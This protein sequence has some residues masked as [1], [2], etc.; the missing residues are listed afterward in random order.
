MLIDKLPVPSRFKRVWM[1]KFASLRQQESYGLLSRA[2][3]AYGL[4]KAADVTKYFGKKKTTVCEFGVAGGDGLLNLISLAERITQE[5]GVEFRI[6][7]FDTGK[8][9]TEV[10][11]YKDHPELW[12]PGDFMMG[13]QEVLKQKIKGR[14]ELILGDIKNTVEP[15]VAS[16]DP[17]APIGFISMDVDLYTS[18]NHALKC[19]VGSPDLYNP[20][21]SMYF[22]DVTFIFANSWC[23]ELAAITEFNEENEFRKIDQD[24]L[25]PG[26][27]SIASAKWYK[28]MYFCHVLD[29]KA[30][31][32]ST[33][34][35]PLSIEDHL[36]MVANNLNS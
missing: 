32:D 18:T 5:T 9:L 16:L 33:Q 36:S 13:D 4:L 27:R 3:Y 26:N 19:L 20:V 21:I 2:N 25:L 23:G 8:G 24:R 17:D 30:R 34:R 11:G 28:K 1:K 6:V 35:K 31:N 14:A 15:F 10:S 22:D 7:G 12:I 29:H